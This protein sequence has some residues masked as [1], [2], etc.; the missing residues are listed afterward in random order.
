MK[1]IIIW[2]EYEKSRTSY[3][4]L[5]G[6]YSDLDGVI[7]GTGDSDISSQEKLESLIFDDSEVRCKHPM[8]ETFPYEAMGSETKV[9]ACGCTGW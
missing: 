4:V 6:D 9:I 3:F 8:S 7:I 5:D 2:N 1:T